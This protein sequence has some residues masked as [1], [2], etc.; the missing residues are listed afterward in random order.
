MKKLLITTWLLAIT[1]FASND[2]SARR[3]LRF[4]TD[5][6]IYHFEPRVI[7]YEQNEDGT[8]YLEP[9]TGEKVEIGE[10]VHMAEIQNFI[11]PVYMKE[12]GLVILMENDSY[13]EL[14]E[15]I[16]SELGDILPDP[17]PE[18]E[19]TLWD[20]F[21]GYMLWFILPIIIV[22]GIVRNRFKKY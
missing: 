8:P 19:Y 13:A 1:I 18:Y 5:Q 16:I 3:S 2:L 7:L 14:N 6:E 12:V 4:G 20:Y 15:E 10:L 11:A 17:L 21:G 22:I 9:I